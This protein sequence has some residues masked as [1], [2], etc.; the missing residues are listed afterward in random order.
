MVSESVICFYMCIVLLPRQLA[1]RLMVLGLRYQSA[2][3][4]IKITWLAPAFVPYRYRQHTVCHMWYDS[5]NIYLDQRII[6]PRNARESTVNNL[7][8]SSPC[9]ITL[10]A[11]YNRASID[12]GVKINVS[13]L[14]DSEF[15]CTTIYMLML[16]AC[17]S[18]H[19][20]RTRQC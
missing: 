13:T 11:V 20:I 2:T 6:L 9:T 17:K 19:Y 8:P 3:T 16:L 15:M 10:R 18:V 7:I 12:S 4:F 14:G 5:Q 1:T